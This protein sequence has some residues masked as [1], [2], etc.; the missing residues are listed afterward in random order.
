MFSKNFFDWLAIVLP[1]GGIALSWWSFRFGEE[2]ATP[3]AL[4][5]YFTTDIEAETLGRG[6]RYRARL[7]ARMLFTAGALLLAAAVP[8]GAAGN[9]ATDRINMFAISGYLILV[10]TA[11]YMGVSTIQI[12]HARRRDAFGMY[13]TKDMTYLYDMKT[14]EQIYFRLNPMPLWSLPNRNWFRTR[15]MPDIH[16]VFQKAGRAQAHDDTQAGVS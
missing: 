1:L 4:V 2:G 11:I 12:L 5:D 13:F 14:T 7:S 10:F 6:I 9:H 3:D 8:M 15:K 16:E